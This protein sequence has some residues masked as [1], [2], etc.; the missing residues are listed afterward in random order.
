MEITLHIVPVYA[1]DF[2]LNNFFL[3]YS[4]SPK[5]LYNIAFLYLEG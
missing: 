2:V 4:F 1:Q 3:V 5:F